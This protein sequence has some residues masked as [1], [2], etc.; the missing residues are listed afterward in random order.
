[1]N[2]HY[3]DSQIEKL[4]IGSY[5]SIAGDV[6]FLLGGNHHTRNFLTYP[7]IKLSEKGSG[8]YS[9]GPIVIEDDVWIGQG[10]MILSGVTI[11]KGAV[12]A[13]RSVVTKDVPPFAIVGGNPA[14]IIKFR[15]PDAMI[16]KLVKINYNDLNTNFICNN[17]EGF[18]TELSTNLI[19][20]I[21][22][23]LIDKI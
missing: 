9:K 12:L 8:S 19:E 16:N 20:T 10:C 13:A 1:M 14:K 17:I 15:F 3:W 4:T 18:N 11:G 6:V 2:I 5:V 22:K 23:H 7:T 21:E